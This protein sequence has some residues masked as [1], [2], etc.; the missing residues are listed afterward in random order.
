[1]IMEK[2]ISEL[3]YRLFNLPQRCFINWL[4]LKG[5]SVAAF[6][7]MESHVHLFIHACKKLFI[8]L[9]LVN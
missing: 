5:R 1:M 6:E 3:F 8:L 7:R 9:T 4:N 2:N